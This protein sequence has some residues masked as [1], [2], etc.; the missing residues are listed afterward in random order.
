MALTF[1]PAAAGNSGVGA[2]VFIPRS[3]LNGIAAGEFG[4]SVASILKNGKA[5]AAL[6]NTIHAALSPTNVSKLGF[7]NFTKS[8]AQGV[9]ESLFRITYSV[10][11]EAVANIDTKAWSLLPLPSTGTYDGVGGVAV[12]DVFP[13]AALVAADGAISGEGILI[14]FTDIEPY[15]SPLTYASI[16][17]GEDNRGFFYGFYQWI[18]GEATVRATGTVSAIISAVKNTVTGLTL[19]AAA[20]D[21]TN[22][23]VGL[24]VSDLKKNH[25]YSI[26]LSVNV[27]FAKDD[28][29][30][31]YDVNP[32]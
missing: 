28:T 12:K 2:G 11:L 16:D 10:N 15:G 19:S 17:V 23:T 22:P 18:V 9:S 29:T 3:D 25:P 4:G 30:Q 24:S 8:A 26:N 1:F 32:A 6:L 7:S 5:V 13:N 31:T 14:L 20:T 27:E 21:A